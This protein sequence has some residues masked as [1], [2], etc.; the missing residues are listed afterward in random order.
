MC[1]RF[2]WCSDYTVL[3]PQMRYSTMASSNMGEHP[4]H[5][6]SK[7]QDLFHWDNRV[8]DFQTRLYP[9]LNDATL[10]TTSVVS[11]NCC[12]LWTWHST[13]EKKKKEW[14]AVSKDAEIRQTY[15]ARSTEKSL[16]HTLWERDHKNKLYNLCTMWINLLLQ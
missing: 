5:G 4:R 16:W 8:N 10:L 7:C 14:N 9:C 11:S 13:W 1:W 6:S 15:F 2:C 12:W 3:F